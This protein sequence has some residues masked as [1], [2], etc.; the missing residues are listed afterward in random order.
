[1]KGLKEKRLAMKLT[2]REFAYKLNISESALNKYERGEREPS[3]ELLKRF[4]DF[5]NCTIDE[6]L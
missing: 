2:R 1:M 5:F 6:L 4:R 3:Q